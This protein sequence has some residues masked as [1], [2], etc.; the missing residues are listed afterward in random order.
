MK[1][2]TWIVAAAFTLAAA[3][4]AGAGDLRP[5]TLLV[6]YGFPSS[7]NATFSVPGAAAELGAYD[8]VVLGDGLEKAT[9]PDHANTVAILAHPD[10]AGTTVFG[11]IDLGVTTQNLSLAEIGLR[12]LEWQSTGADGVFFDDFGYDFGVDRARQSA[13]VD[14]AHA[15]GLAVVANAFRVADAFDDAVDPVSNPTGDAT[16]LGAGDL[17]LYESHQVRLNA[18]EAEAA[19]Q[20]KA[21]EVEALRLAHGFGVFS[22]TTT[23]V[24]DPAAFEQEKLDYA[25][26]SAL[27]YGHV[28]TGWGEYAFSASGA[29]NSLAPFR[30]RPSV[31]PGASFTS[32]V[33]ANPPLYTR[34]TD[35][36]TISVDAVAHVASFVPG[37]NPVPLSGAGVLALLLCA[38]GAW[39][40][41]RTRRR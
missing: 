28:A 4:E 31:A 24:D 19:W 13:A 23:D 16:H 2:A 7:I 29:S 20:A 25:W 1:H 22:I 41:R 33:V 21:N 10:M 6:Y 18:Y 39:A 35:A 37:A 32:V 15:A 17:Y 27:L 11:Y 36:G 12:V 9:H 14:A 26:F 34:D 38:G 40:I 5:R 8:H 3:G 30:A